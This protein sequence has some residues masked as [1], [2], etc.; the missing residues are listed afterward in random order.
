MPTYIFVVYLVIL[1]VFFVVG[2]FVTR[3]LKNDDKALAFLWY[4]VGFALL[5]VSFT[6]QGSFALRKD[7]R[8]NIMI[9]KNEIMKVSLSH[10]LT[11]ES[12]LDLLDKIC[13]S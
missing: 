1:F 9:C 4:L 13:I 8:Q 10:F 2:L 12:T 5:V 7:N 6:I 11:P 3:A